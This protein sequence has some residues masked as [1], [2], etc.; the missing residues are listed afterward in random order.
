M[1]HDQSHDYWHPWY[2]TI[3]SLTYYMDGGCRMKVCLKVRMQQWDN[4]L[5]DFLPPPPT[6]QTRSWKTTVCFSPMPL[7]GRNKFWE[8][9]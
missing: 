5:F 1:P 3:S 7:N 8:M 6:R 2:F 9:A 4:Q